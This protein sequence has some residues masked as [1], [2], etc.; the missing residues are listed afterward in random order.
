MP[1]S[2]LLGF[3]MFLWFCNTLPFLSVSPPAFPVPPCCSSHPAGHRW[4]SQALQ[5][6]V[7]AHPN[8]RPCRAA[9][10]PPFP[11]AAW[12]LWSGQ[13]DP[14]SLLLWFLTPS[15]LPVLHWG[16]AL[17]CTL[18]WTC[19]I[20]LAVEGQQI[21]SALSYDV[22]E[23]GFEGWLGRSSST[24]APVIA[25]T[26]PGFGKGDFLMKWRQC[27]RHSRQGGEFLP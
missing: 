21:L 23:C 14:S 27:G 8:P 10:P 7:L 18:S 19:H 2:L 6:L 15:L 24:S 12:A 22:A 25:P 4:H 16:A 26:P 3:V 11:A 5:C 9:W 1:A 20:C 17:H 13:F